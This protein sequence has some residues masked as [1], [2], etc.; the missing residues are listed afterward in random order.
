MNRPAKKIQSPPSALD[1]VLADDYQAAPD[2]LSNVA[3]DG[4]L[5]SESMICSKALDFLGELSA[6]TEKLARNNYS[7]E[8]SGVLRGVLD[9]DGDDELLEMPLLDPR[10]GGNFMM[11]LETLDRLKK[12]L[13]VVR[14]VLEVSPWELFNVQ[15]LVSEEGRLLEHIGRVSE[16]L[17]RIKAENPEWADIA[18]ASAEVRREISDIMRSAHTVVNV[19]FSSGTIDN[20]DFSS[21]K[22]AEKANEL[23]MVGAIVASIRRR[24]GK[25][26]EADVD[27]D[28]NI[29]ELLQVI[30]NCVQLLKAL[31][32]KSPLVNFIGITGRMSDALASGSPEGAYEA[33]TALEKDFETV[34]LNTGDPDD[35]WGSTLTVFIQS[36][37]DVVNDDCDK[38]I[39]A[40]EKVIR[41]KN[42]RKKSGY[43]EWVKACAHLFQ[44]IGKMA[45]IMPDTVIWRLWRCREEI[46]ISVFELSVS[47]LRAIRNELLQTAEFYKMVKTVGTL[48]RQK[49]A[50]ERLHAEITRLRVMNFLR[51]LDEIQDGKG[52]APANH[53]PGNSHDMGVDVDP[54]EDDELDEIDDGD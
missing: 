19:L 43:R 28:L 54:D 24:L 6:M 34:K 10:R 36:I 14:R 4:P 45:D 51:K 53:D 16:V 50:F 30:N 32:I 8:A 2:S 13:A 7:D 41:L 35:V 42:K 18:N 23:P 11:L 40:G 12:G 44:K 3:D 15:K 33:L 38:L 31:A 26:A 17:D 47:T 27:S 20:P 52:D 29:C 49:G 39:A 37:H 25:A 22:L 5:S 1:D 9:S 48:L 21:E 46:D